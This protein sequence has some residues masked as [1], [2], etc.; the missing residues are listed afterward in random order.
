MD[1]IERCAVVGVGAIGA[2][3]AARLFDA[4]KDVCVV[5]EGTRKARYERE[6]FIVNG[7]HYLWP[8]ADRAIACPTV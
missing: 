1:R 7:R 3:L 5:A 6:G 2:S 8:V 4:D